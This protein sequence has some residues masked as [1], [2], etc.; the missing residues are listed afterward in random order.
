MNIG[1]SLVDAN[2]NI[3]NLTRTHLAQT[4]GGLDIFDIS[5]YTGEYYLE[6]ITGSGTGNSVFYSSIVFKA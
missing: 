2:G 6:L 3:N 5:D 4:A 1:I